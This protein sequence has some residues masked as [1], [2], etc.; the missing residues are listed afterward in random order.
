MPGLWLDNT[1]SPQTRVTLRSIAS[2][3]THNNGPNLSKFEGFADLSRQVRCTAY[4]RTGG[5]T[6]TGQAKPPRYPRPLSI[7]ARDSP[8]CVGC[9]PDLVTKS[10]P[11]H[12]DSCPSIWVEL[13][14]AAEAGTFLVTI[15][16]IITHFGFRLSRAQYPSG[17]IRA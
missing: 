16:S 15:L 8:R 3:R 14:T 1:F 5:N 17:P 6:A 4:C 11:L 7:R 10:R 2:Y 9:Y 13:E 12:K